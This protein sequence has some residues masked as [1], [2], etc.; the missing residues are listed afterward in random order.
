MGKTRWKTE[1][2]NKSSGYSSSPIRNQSLFYFVII[3]EK[4]PHHTTQHGGLKIVGMISINFNNDLTAEKLS[5][6]WSDSVRSVQIK[7]F[8][9]ICFA[10]N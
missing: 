8:L 3:G 4:T 10:V 9:F 7:H 6:I 1:S 5:N 2:K